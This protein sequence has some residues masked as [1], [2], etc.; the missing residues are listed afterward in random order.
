MAVQWRYSLNSNMIVLLL[1][2]AALET[3]SKY[4]SGARKAEILRR[5]SPAQS[6]TTWISAAANRGLS[7]A[8]PGWPPPGYATASPP[9]ACIIRPLFKT[10]L[11][12]WWNL[13][14]EWWNLVESST[15]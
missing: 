4:F 10:V 6:T 11:T 8:N 3:G 15:E 5:W 7:Y 14:T 2:L 12:K 1:G 13:V 9:Y